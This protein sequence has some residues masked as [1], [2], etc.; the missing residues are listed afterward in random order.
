MKYSLRSLMIAVLVGPPLLAWLIVV[1]AALIRER[2]ERNRPY[3]APNR[4]ILTQQFL[5]DADLA[6]PPEETP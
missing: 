4:S 6:A 5:D 3:F 1:A 2:A